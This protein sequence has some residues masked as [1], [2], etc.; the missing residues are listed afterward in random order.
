MRRRVAGWRSGGFRNLVVVIDAA[1][2]RVGGGGG[3]GGGE[4]RGVGGGRAGGVFVGIERA[5][6]RLD[7]RFY[8]RFY[9]RAGAVDELAGTVDDGDRLPLC[10][11]SRMQGKVLRYMQECV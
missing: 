11:L 8:V 7:V 3:G 5:T 9:V 10:L 2:A 4:G 6:E 1:P